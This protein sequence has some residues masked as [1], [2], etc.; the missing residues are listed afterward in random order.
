[1]VVQKIELQN[2]RN[3]KTS[4]INF[5][6]S[7]NIFY[8]KNAQGKTN[9]LEAINLISSL[10]SFRTSKD[11]ELVGWEQPSARVKAWI[12]GNLVEVFILEGEKKV[13]VN[14]STKSV[15]DSW[16]VLKVVSFYPQEVF[17]LTSSPD[18]RR[19]YLDAMISLSDKK[20]LRTVIELPKILRNRNKVLFF[21]K[22][23]R[24]SE[25]Q[26]EV[27]DS[28][29]IEAGVA[30]WLKRKE[31]MEKINGILK[32]TQPLFTKGKP[33]LDYH[34]KL[35]LNKEKSELKEAFGKKLKDL[36]DQ[37][38]ERSVSLLGPHRDDFFFM[39]ENGIHKKDLSIFG[40]RGEQKTAI[41]TIKLSE[42]E[43][44]ESETGARPALLLDEVLSELDAVHQQQLM[45]L[46]EQQQT[47]ITSTTLDRYPEEILKKA[48]VFRVEEG[49]VI[50]EG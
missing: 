40:S 30:I 10:R 8:G 14:N 1:M 46:L 23:G 5:S 27:W 31:V 44:I 43:L 45:G 9:L 48:K 42:L 41:L 11:S 3:L 20:Y 39:L 47:F 36:R 7:L 4:L 37:E 15:T 24:S 26:L 13:L 6:P 29:L 50:E 34:P 16:G 32:K 49:K 38:I 25:A 22:E 19:K 28:T 35:P 18:R 33:F 17:L 2:F 12:G 21:I